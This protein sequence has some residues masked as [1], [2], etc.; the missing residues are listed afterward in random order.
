EVKSYVQRWRQAHPA[1]TRFWRRL[2]S[3]IKRTV[4]TGE[5]GTL[6]RLA[7]E[8]ADG[9]LRIVLPS[10]RRIYYPQAHLVP[11]KFAGTTQVSF[12]DNARGGWFDN[13]AWYGVFVENV[14]QATARDLLA[15]AMQRLERA[16][17]PVV[18]TVH[19]EIV[20]EVPEGFGDIDEFHRLMIEPPP[21]VEGLPIAAKVRTGQHYSKSPKT[22]PSPKPEITPVSIPPEITLVSTAHAQ[23]VFADDF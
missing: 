18:L 7:F 1:T 4:R 17:Y 5:R 11:G 14:V 9:T 21:W 8:M 15:A 6:G 20:C 19:D 16:G 12:K 2:E 23:E 13:R 10:G 22:A 3:A